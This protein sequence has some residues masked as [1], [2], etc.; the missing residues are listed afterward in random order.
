MFKS[1]FQTH[2]G[3][4]PVDQ[5]FVWVGEYSNGEHLAEFDLETKEENSFRSLDKDKL[6]RFGLIGHK[7]KLFFESNGIFNLNG[8]SVEVFY[9]VGEKVIPLTG[10]RKVNYQDIITYKDAES[11]LHPRGGVLKTRINQFNFG[12][13]TLI[14]NEEANFNFKPIVKIPFNNPAHINFWLVSDQDLDGEFVIVRNG[15]EHEVID[16]PLKAHVGGELNWVVK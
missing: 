14:E 6:I 16:A 2:N 13:K 10:N 5:E 12:Y 1:I 8:L 4:S 7:M 15:K 3:R 11:A 9:R